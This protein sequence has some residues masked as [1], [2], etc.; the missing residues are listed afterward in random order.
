MTHVTC[1][2]F[3]WKYTT[4]TLVLTHRTWGAMR[5]RVTMARILHSEIVTFYRSSKPFT[6]RHATYI[7]HLASTE[8]VHFKLITQFH[9]RIFTRSNAKFFDHVARFNIRFRKML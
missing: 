2:A 3:S 5:Q 4:R 9:F 1:H 6:T 8:H 7:D